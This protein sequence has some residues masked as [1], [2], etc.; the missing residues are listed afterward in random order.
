VLLSS[1]DS[2][3]HLIQKRSSQLGFL[4]YLLNYPRKLVYADPGGCAFIGADL[5]PLASQYCGFKSRRGHWLSVSWD[6]AVL[7]DTG[8][9]DGP[10][11]HPEDTHWVWYIWVCSKN[12]TRKPRP[13][14]AVVKKKKKNLCLLRILFHFDN[15]RNFARISVIHGHK[16]VPEYA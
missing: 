6:C 4:T 7:S 5:R 3:P 15:H 12:L 16:C 14:R 1:G 8:L 9:C 11:T 2:F 10:I 13:S